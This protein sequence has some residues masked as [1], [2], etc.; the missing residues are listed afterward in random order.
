MRP[1][2]TSLAESIIIRMQVVLVSGFVIFLNL[3]GN[4]HL[5]EKPKKGLPS[6]SFKGSSFSANT[7]NLSKGSPS[8]SALS[9]ASVNNPSVI[10]KPPERMSTPSP[11]A[12]S[13]IVGAEIAASPSE[14]S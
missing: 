1:K 6:A 5:G 3:V 13:P 7:S 4:V 2:S 9:P 10:L 8:I 12:D 11:A 14:S